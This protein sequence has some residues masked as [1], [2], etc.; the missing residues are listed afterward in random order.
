[1]LKRESGGKRRWGADEGGRQLFTRS[2][3]EKIVN[4]DE[5]DG[6]RARERSAAAVDTPRPTQIPT[7]SPHVP[8]KNRA[9]IHR[10]TLP[11]SNGKTGS[12]LH[13]PREKLMPDRRKWR[14]FAQI[15]PKIML[16]A[17]PHSATAP[18]SPYPSS[19][20]GSKLAP[21]MLKMIDFMEEWHS[22]MAKI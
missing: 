19:L 10:K 22:F 3:R 20:P 13:K 21:K 18:S 9:Q 7:L 11:P 2:Q 5:P 6:S 12:K 1:M 15:R 14:F 17:G 8:A 16:S 4:V